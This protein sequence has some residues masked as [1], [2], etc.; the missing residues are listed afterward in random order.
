MTFFIEEEPKV[1][2]MNMSTSHFLTCFVHFAYYSTLKMDP[3]KKPSNPFSYQVT[4][5]VLYV[6]GAPESI[7]ER[8]SSA[9]H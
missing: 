6:K 2:Q 1:S 3:P 8:C 5:P 9:L 4:G 7:L